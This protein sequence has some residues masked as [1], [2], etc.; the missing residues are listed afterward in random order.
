MNKRL[1]WFSM[2]PALL[3]AGSSVAQHPML[4]KIADKVV[5]KPLTEGCWD[6]TTHPHFPMVCRQARRPSPKQC[7]S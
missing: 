6:T 1:L 5:Q 3:F 7:S 4:D 2:A